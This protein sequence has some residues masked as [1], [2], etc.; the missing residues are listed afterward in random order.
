MIIDERHFCLAPRSCRTTTPGKVA[1]ALHAI[2]WVTKRSLVQ[3]ELIYLNLHGRNYIYA[4]FV[5]TLGTK[6]LR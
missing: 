1:D 2:K 3:K 6:S 4:K 5:W